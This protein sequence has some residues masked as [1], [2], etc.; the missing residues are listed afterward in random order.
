MERHNSGPEKKQL[1]GH[2]RNKIGNHKVPG[3]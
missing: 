1:P 3:I 2:R